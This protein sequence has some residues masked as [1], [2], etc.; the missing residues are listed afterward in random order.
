[1][2]TASLSFFFP[3]HPVRCHHVFLKEPWWRCV[4]CGRGVKA[5]PLCV[6]YSEL[7]GDGRVRGKFD[8]FVAMW[9]FPP[10]H[11]PD[12]LLIT[13]TAECWGSGRKLPVEPWAN[14]LRGPLIG[15]KWPVWALRHSWPCLTS[16]GSSER[17][18]KRRG[19]G[20]RERREVS[21]KNRQPFPHSVSG[22]RSP[23]FS[24]TPRPP[25]LSFYLQL[26]S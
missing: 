7:W 3:L 21:G 20:Q 6:L 1:M 14:R 23:T 11:P 25:S 16:A 19:G 10:T 15:W 17:E 5:P 8:H 26:Y 24:P 4:G 13:S 2:T 9:P 12:P 18:R 22:D